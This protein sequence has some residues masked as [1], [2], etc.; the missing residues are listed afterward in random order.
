MSI[1]K[2]TLRKLIEFSK[3][4]QLH[5]QQQRQASG[6]TTN[7]ATNEAYQ[8][9]IESLTSLLAEKTKRPSRKSEDK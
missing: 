6:Q 8:R 3:R 1:V 9:T 7:T 2:D 5:E 4:Q